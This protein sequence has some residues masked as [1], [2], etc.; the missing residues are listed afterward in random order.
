MGTEFAAASFIVS[1]V[2]SVREARQAQKASRRAAERREQVQRQQNFRRKQQELR[3]AR[4][5]R[6]QAV[7]QG[8][9]SGAEIGG[10]SAVQG[11]TA[12]IR[13][14]AT[15]NI[16]FLD[17]QTRAGA[18]IT[19]HTLASN[20]ATAQANLFGEIAAGSQQI[21]NIF[22]EVTTDDTTN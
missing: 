22:D 12:S 18:D 9:A 17:E 1:T 11:T 10:T 7:A 2:L 16:S 5:A 13:S 3:Q 19:R 21:S 4:A 20:E 14:Q 8:A 15:S 6:A